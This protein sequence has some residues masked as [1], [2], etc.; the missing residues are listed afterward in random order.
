VT[1]DTASSIGRGQIRPVEA[2]ERRR[3]NIAVMGSTYAR[4]HEDSQVP[5]LREAVNRLAARG[6]RLT[7]IVPSF[8]GL[9]HHRI[10][11]I[12]VLRFRYAPRWVEQLTHD[13]GAPNKLRNPMYQLLGVS[14]IAMGTLCSVAWSLPRKF[15]VINVHWPFPHGLFALS[16]ARATGAKVVATCHGAELAMGRRKPWIRKILRQCLLRSDRLACNS[17]HTGSE[18][19]KVCGRT[20]TV[21]PYGATTAIP[22][23]TTNRRPPSRSEPATILFTGRHIQRKGVPYL[24]RA[25]PRLLK[26]RPVRLL[27][28]GDGDRRCEWEELTR[29]LGLS[30]VVD[31]LG[32]VS[33]ERLAELYRDCDVYVLPAIFDD[34]GDTEG[35]GVVLIEAL[36]NA[37]PVVASAVGG[38]VDV[39]KHEETGLLV[40]EKDEAALAAA[41]LRLLDDPGLAARLGAGGRKHAQEYF[42]WDRAV[43][44]TETLFYDAL[45]GACVPAHT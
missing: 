26:H 43:T 11:G 6:H 45:G 13:E 29:S 17:S 38:I 30:Q 7:V 14:Y 19:E 28:T 18:I 20:A 4:F 39:I 25:M 22:P 35:L 8:K 33:N 40:P 3:L 37:K 15:D 24:I 32:F 34:R 12:E 31:F 10:D 41:I 16:A 23:A 21:I 9:R 5:W 1:L 44:A 2:S 42:D 36:A 27:L